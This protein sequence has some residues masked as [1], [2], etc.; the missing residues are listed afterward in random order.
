MTTRVSGLGR[1][2]D[3]GTGIHTVNLNT[4]SVTGKA[5]S[6]QNCGGIGVLVYKSADGTTDDLQ[7]DLQEAVGATGSPQD[8]DII[9]D[10][11]VKSETVLDNDEVWTLTTQAA[12][13]EIAAIAGTAELEIMLYFEVM[14]DQLS[15]TYTHILCNVPDLG[16][17][18]TGLGGVL[19]IPFNLK[20]Q[21]NPANLASLLSPGTANV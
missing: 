1:L 8:L 16:S 17:V 6:M 2:F 5:I 4:G 7:C 13:S 20:V 21:R 14:D 18:D 11:W 12:A 10:Y 15:D 9:T 19:Y 3:I